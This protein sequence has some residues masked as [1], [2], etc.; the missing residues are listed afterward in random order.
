[1]PNVPIRIVIN[2]SDFSSSEKDISILEVEIALE[3]AVA[4]ALSELF[5]TVLVE[6][7]KVTYNPHNNSSITDIHT[8]VSR[9]KLTEDTAESIRDSLGRKLPE[10]RIDSVVIKDVVLESALIQIRIKEEPLTAQNLSTII[11]SLTD[12]H[13]KCW[14]IYHRRFAEL[15]EYT[16]THD[17]RFSKQANL[18]ITQL[19]HNSPAEIKIDAGIKDIA[20]ALKIGIDA[21]IQSPL[22]YKAAKL[23][24]EAKALE[25][26]LKEQE[27]HLAREDKEQ[28]RTIEAQRAEIEIQTARLRV[29]QQQLELEQQRLTLQKAILE[30]EH[31]RI[32]LAFETASKIVER[33]AL[34]ADEASKG[35]LVQVLLPQLLQLGSSNGLELILP[36]SQGNQNAEKA[37]H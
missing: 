30:A 37:Q 27:A 29:A 32:N 36:S 7:V 10:M 14:L 23:E 33:L 20:E 13:T 28:A 2:T 6:E 24:N 21:F 26:T 1:L 11:A 34:N 17:I 3:S 15:I 4:S 19:S 31:Q 18:I 9:D 35:M 8:V 5:D 25:T 16:Q 22:R 12:L